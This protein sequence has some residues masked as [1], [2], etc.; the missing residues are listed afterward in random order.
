MVMLLVSASSLYAKPKS[1]SGMWTLK[2]TEQG[3][4]PMVL[5]Q[6]GKTVS[7]SIDGPH[8]TISLKGEFANG[9][10][11]MDGTSEA[12]KLSATGSLK[13]DGSLAGSMKSNM[14]DMDWT[15]V[16]NASKL[17]PPK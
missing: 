1:V 12:I 13:G 8:G 5:L 15:A 9:Q 17:V 16:R 7:G 11:K 4:Y 2:V 14:G 3:S 6:K 10:L